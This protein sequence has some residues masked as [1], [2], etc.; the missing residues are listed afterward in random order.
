MN[1]EPDNSEEA[2]ERDLRRALAELPPERAPASLRR[3]LRAIPRRGRRWQ[4]LPAWRPGWALLLLALPLALVIA[5]QQQ[6]LARQEQILAS[7]AREVAQARRE[8]ALALSYV[9][10]ANSIANR[11]IAEALQSGLARPVRDNTIYGLNKPLE[12][13]KEYQL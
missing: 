5:L 12:I 13:T 3:K 2:W 7:Q 9:E 1:D 4:W 11:Q 10:K 8:L 6:H